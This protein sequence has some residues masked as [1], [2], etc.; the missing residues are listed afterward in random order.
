[1]PLS[2][3]GLLPPPYLPSPPETD[4]APDPPESHRTDASLCH[5]G[6]S[7]AELADPLER[8]SRTTPPVEERRT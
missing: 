3:P 6:G 4:E 7:D 2:V 5:T 8:R 1:M